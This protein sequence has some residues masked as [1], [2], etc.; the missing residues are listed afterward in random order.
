MCSI[1]TAAHYVRPVT[2]PLTIYP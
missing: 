2:K 1:R